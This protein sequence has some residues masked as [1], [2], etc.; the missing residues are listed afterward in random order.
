M[1][2][3][4]LGHMPHS[5]YILS[6]K[7]IFIN[8]V[9]I[10]SR[11]ISFLLFIEVQLSYNLVIIT[12]VQRS[13]S[14]AHIDILFHILFHCGL[15]QDIDKVLCAIQQDLVCFLNWRIIALQCCVGF[16]RTTMQISHNFIYICARPRLECRRETGL[17]LRCDRKVG[18]PF[19]TKQGSRPYCP[20]QEGR[21]GSEEVLPENFGV[22]LEGDRDVGALCG[23]HQ[24]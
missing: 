17:I 24:G 5:Q 6:A 15:S 19:Q 3:I 9:F 2:S 8:T 11:Q 13:D 1:V 10:C 21:R 16:C 7:W 18:N 14:V 20:D 12:A 22:P 23:S 4:H